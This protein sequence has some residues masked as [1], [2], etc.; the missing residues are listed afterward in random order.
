MF[1]QESLENLRQHI[2]LV[3]LLSAH[4]DLKRAGSVFK[5]RCPFHEEKTPSFIVKRG[6][7]HYHCFGCGA[8][9]D[10]IAF[11][12]NH[13][14]MSFA[15]SVESLAERFGVTLIKSSAPSL[16]G[17]SRARLKEVLEQARQFYHFLLLHSEAGHEALHYL[18]RR[19]IDLAFI[20]RFH[21]GFAPQTRDSFLK[22]AHA[23]GYDT[24]TL[25]QAGLIKRG[26]RERS[27]DFFSDRILF[28]I[29]DGMGATIGFSGRKFRETTQGGKYINTPETALFKKS[30]ILF[31]LAH[32]RKRI[33]KERRLLLVEG[34]IDALRLIE[35]GFDYVVAAQGTAFGEGHIAELLQLGVTDAYLALDSDS[36]G[37]EAAWKIGSLLQKKGVHVKVVLLPEDSDPDSFLKDYGPEAFEQAIQ[38]AI[39]YL[40]FAF[41]WRAKGVDLKIPAHKS[42]LFEEFAQ[43]I[44]GWEKPVMVFETLRELAQ[45]AGVPEEVAGLTSMHK[46]LISRLGRRGNRD[47]DKQS[48][49][50]LEMDLVRWAL[51]SGPH[52]KEVIE[53]IA[54]NVSLSSLQCTICAKLLQISLREI[55]EGRTLDLLSCASVFEGGEESRFFSDL[56]S[57]KI[58][59]QQPINGCRATIKNWLE[60]MWLEEM[61]EIKRKIQAGTL[62]DEQAMALAKRYAEIRKKPPEVRSEI[63]IDLS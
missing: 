2:D 63:R 53:L 57:K 62:E 37:C 27:S 59:L 40:Q 49:Q 4:I 31:G 47:A 39:G 41:N 35:A 30:H 45:L 56:L 1:L 34:Q 60:K 21:I 10:A 23:K 55:R 7:S 33:V 19:G 28:P 50:P 29:Q 13:L 42:G 20:S 24:D 43:Q 25:E 52:Q 12:M 46:P 3:E 61:E 38:G 17:P 22:F 5:A 58:N 44:R 15:D 8:H 11:L 48:V 36:A 14:R 6:D 32:S 54:A 51:L 18:Y 26:E 9:G 16:Q